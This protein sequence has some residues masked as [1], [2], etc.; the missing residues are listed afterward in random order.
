MNTVQLKR[1]GGRSAQVQALVRTALEELVAEQG[2]ER[3]TVPAVAERA[4]VSASSIYRRWGDL[5]SLLSET[6]IHRLDPN[7][8]LPDS[9]SLKDDIAAWARE[10]ILHVAKPC[11]TSLLKAAA[12]L[13]RDKDSD[14]LHNRKAEAEVLVQR[15]RLRGESTP[16]PQQVIDHV[17]APIVF[18]LL[19]GGDAVTPALA[20]QLVDELFRLVLPTPAAADR[21]AER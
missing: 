20:A 21:V 11:N 6:A 10:F 14:C 12:A 19:F 1:P 5:S 3:V 18:R 7:R 2:R 16:E 9:G 8:P 13:A 4:G 15:A 17:V